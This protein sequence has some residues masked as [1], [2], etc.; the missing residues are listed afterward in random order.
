MEPVSDPKASDLSTIIQYGNSARQYYPQQGQEWERHLLQCESHKCTANRCS[1]E[2]LF[3]GCRKDKI[4]YDN[5]GCLETLVETSV[6]S[7][8]RGLTGCVCNPSRVTSPRAFL[9]VPSIIDVFCFHTSGGY[10]ESMERC[11]VFAK[12]S[13]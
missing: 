1:R 8:S 10:Y 7:V 11:T 13:L 6:T 3:V 2:H 4:A 9:A 5:C 12:E